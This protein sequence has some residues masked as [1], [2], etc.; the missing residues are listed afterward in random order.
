MTKGQER[1][2][3]TRERNERQ[4]E[5]IHVREGLHDNGSSRTLSN[6]ELTYRQAFSVR[7]NCFWEQVSGRVVVS[8]IE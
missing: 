2:T 3:S 5:R 8:S 4:R 7:R 6:G 1:T